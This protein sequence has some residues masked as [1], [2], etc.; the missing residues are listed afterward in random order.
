MIIKPFY[1]SDHFSIPLPT[2]FTSLQLNPAPIETKILDHRLRFLFE[3]LLPPSG[4]NEFPPYCQH[5]E[6]Q[7]VL[8]KLE[9]RHYKKCNSGQ[10]VQQL[11]HDPL[12]FSP[13]W[14]A[15]A[16]PLLLEFVFRLLGD[17][18]VLMWMWCKY[19]IVRMGANNKSKTYTI[20]HDLLTFIC[21]PCYGA[22]SDLWHNEWSHLSQVGDISGRRGRDALWSDVDGAKASDVREH[23]EGRRR[24][25]RG[26]CWCECWA[27]K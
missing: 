22:A 15:G 5:T 14:G 18:N 17:T 7:S 1:V 23:D 6:Q 19:V 24:W 21:R 9:L 27:K 25:W 3:W 13:W 20:G 26:L 11:C 4:A 16:Q 12:Q 2:N 8:L 10:P